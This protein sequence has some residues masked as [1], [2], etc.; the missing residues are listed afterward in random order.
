MRPVRYEQTP[1]G[2]VAFQQALT[3]S[4]GAPAQTLIVMEATSTY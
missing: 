1:D 3:P 4:G 2:F